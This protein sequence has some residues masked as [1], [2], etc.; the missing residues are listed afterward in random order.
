MYI[1]DKEPFIILI[2]SWSGHQIHIYEPTHLLNVFENAQLLFPE[3]VL[4]I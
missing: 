4:P 1:N 3:I 2:P